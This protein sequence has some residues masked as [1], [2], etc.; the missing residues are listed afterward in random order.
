MS[1]H[2]KKGICFLVCSFLLYSCSSN[3]GRY[4]KSSHISQT[5]KLFLNKEFD[6][7]ISI[8]RKKINQTSKKDRLLYLMEA[9]SIFHSIGL[10]EES[11]LAL[12]EA[13]DI[14]ERTYKSISQN[15]KGYFL[16]DSAKNYYPEVFERILIKLY[17]AMNFIF[18]D[19]REKALK[20]FQ[21]IEIEQREIRDDDTINYQQNLF[22]R[23]L[24][25]VLAESLGYYN[26]A[27]VQYNNLLLSGYQE[28]LIKASL[29]HLAKKEEDEEGV[30]EYQPF[31]E[32]LTLFNAQMEILPF[33][34]LIL[35][36]DYGELVVIYEYGL[37]PYKKG[38]GK[39][40]EDRDFASFLNTSYLLSI[41]T[42]NQL[43]VNSSV[44]LTFIKNSENPIPI[45]EKREDP[46]DGTKLNFSLNGR[47]FSTEV[48]DDY[49]K[50]VIRNYNE[51]YPK[52]VNKNV[53]TILS[54]VITSLAAGAAVSLA[55]ENR[56]LGLLTNIFGSIAIS[57]SIKPDLRS[58]NLAYKNLQMKRIFL[59]PGIYQIT[60]VGKNQTRYLSKFDR[61]IT[62][63]KDKTSFLKVRQF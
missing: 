5:E 51:N 17:I 47:S 48:V 45:Y 40:G 10:W 39:I 41:V 7:A 6:K 8:L 60:S 28:D 27:R 11:N 59:K 61:E 38:R 4:A 62:I 20:Y 49:E 19:E 30:L 50:T 23:Y 31:G 18:L 33:T 26:E 35:T 15:I 34:N 12:L 29:F 32:D 42:K 24:Y 13:D 21:K 46:F 56:L 9:G 63:E 16:N 58:W 54:K 37:A 57:A 25:A 1:F 14:A 36:N 22:A 53:F 3:Y 55:T 2:F 52:Y 44:L 43:A